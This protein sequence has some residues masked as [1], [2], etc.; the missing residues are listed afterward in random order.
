MSDPHVLAFAQAFDELF[1]QASVGHVVEIF[2]WLQGAAESYV[3]MGVSRDVFHFGPGGHVNLAAA[4]ATDD[5]V[6]VVRTNS[7]TGENLDALTGASDEFRDQ[8]DAFGHGVFLSAGEDASDA[9]IDELI[10]SLKGIGSDV[11]G[12]MK[13]GL[14]V[15]DDAAD[16][17]GAALIN[18][19]VFFQD[20]EDDAIDARID[21]GCGIA[22]HGG[23][24]SVGIAEAAATRTHHGDHGNFEPALGLVDGPD[25]R[26][27]SA[28]K[29]RGAKLHTI[30]AAGFGLN[31]VVDR[32][33]TDFEQDFWHGN[34]IAGREQQIPHR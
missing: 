12:A 19:A 18:A 23:E 27:E 13:D 29:E 3:A 28:E 6:H 8:I 21:G 25:G 24:F 1:H 30:G 17:R 33:A 26:R 16:A 2:W 31:G 32:S 5:V 10:E 15:A 14:A 34:M 22:F 4:G 7:A 11:E 9:E 20:A